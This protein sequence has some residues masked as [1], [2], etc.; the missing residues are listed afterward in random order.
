[1]TAPGP[2]AGVNPFVSDG[3][4]L[5]CALHTH[6]TESD[7]S[8]TPERLAVNYR[9]SGYDVMAI[10]DHWRRTIVSSTEELITLPAAELCF[11]LVDPPSRM[12]GEFLAYGIR[13]LPDDP[14]G[15]RD[16][17]WFNQEENYE[18][19]TFADLDAGM[20]WVADQGAVAYIAHPYW[21]GLDPQVLLDAQGFLG[22][23][24]YNGSSELETGR[25]DS[26]AWWDTLLS[27]GHQAFA[28]A[29]DDQ[30]VPL[31]D[32]GTAW[33]MVR[34]AERTP[35]AVLE[36]LRTGNA[37]SSNGPTIH[38]VVVDG[39]HVEVT[40]SPVRSVVLA[41]EE[42]CGVSVSAGA[43]GRRFGRI[44]ETNDVGL[45][46]RARIESPWPEPRYRR[47]TVVDATGAK[48][49]TNPLPR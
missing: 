14:G 11:D 4:W 35:A 30:H 32:L 5:K 41:M 21:S 44:L 26:S 23:E 31:F 22:L 7:G 2:V 40:C 39:P 34:A 37:Y 13:D 10:T 42:E 46:T 18:V 17:W 9:D 33:T 3:V 24:V 12:V 15:N 1:M 48:A 27:A 8:L 28:I 19:R 43:R 6:T 16:N 38:H 45:I 47:I 20:S 49:W 29:T 36:A 25:G